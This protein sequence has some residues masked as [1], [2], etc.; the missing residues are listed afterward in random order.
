[1]GL[2]SYYAYERT[3]GAVAEDLYIFNICKLYLGKKKKKKDVIT[4]DLELRY[5]SHAVSLEHSA[6]ALGGALEPEH[7]QDRVSGRDT[8]DSAQGHLC[9]AGA[10]GRTVTTLPLLKPQPLLEGLG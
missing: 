3:Q 2:H 7:R 9:C 6:T 1:M 4:I 10:P 5:G 8:G